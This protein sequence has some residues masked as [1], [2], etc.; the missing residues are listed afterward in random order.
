[1]I[2]TKIEGDLAIEIRP[3]NP[4]TRA[5]L[6]D[7]SRRCGAFQNLLRKKGELLA[8]LRTA[9]D[10]PFSLRRRWL[11]SIDQVDLGHANAGREIDFLVGE[12]RAAQDEVNDWLAAW[13]A[14]QQPYLQ[15]RLDSLA[16][17]SIQL[18]R[19]WR[20]YWSLFR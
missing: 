5:V 12:F 1:M 18:A 9:D 2:K 8:E 14:T 3:V 19:S 7:K 6:A 10:L 16:R 17:L 13:D 20:Q 15:E 4:P 11:R